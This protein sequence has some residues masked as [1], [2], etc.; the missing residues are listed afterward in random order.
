MTAKSPA[1]ISQPRRLGY[2]YR[3]NLRER[4]IEAL[5]F[6][7]A[8]ASVAI[9]LAIVVMLVKE[10]FDFFQHVSIWDFLTDT[11]WTPLFDDAHYGILPLVSGTLVSSAVALLVAI[12]LGTI[13]AI[14]LS[15]FAPFAVREIAKPFLEL[16]GGVPT[17]VYGYFALLFVTPLLQKIFPELPGFSLL[18]AGLVMGIMIIP[19]VS[20]LSEDAMRA[21][22][23]SMRE[24]SYAMG[25]TRFQTA[26]RVVMPAAYSGIAAAYILGIS[27]A[28]GET[29]VVAVAAGMQPNLTWNPMEPAATITA[30]I[31][32]VSLGDLPHGSIGYQTI[33]AA[34]LTLL[35]MTLSFNIIGH[36]LR[37]RYREIY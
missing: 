10:S 16:L 35:L 9:T 3:R 18:S 31:V 27:R 26:I 1:E 21:V 15:E 23:M 24:G 20:S 25:A 5:L 30:Y 13:I 28:V 37:K 22:P 12:P 6:L 7:T 36:I 29:M 4:F 34:G 2:S 14:Y 11:Q 8:F 32:Q 19:Y 33:F 17:I